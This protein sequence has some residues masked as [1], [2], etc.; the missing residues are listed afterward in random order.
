MKTLEQLFKIFI[1]SAESNGMDVQLHDKVEQYFDNVDT[2]AAF[3]LFTGAY[4][5]GIKD[6]DKQHW[7]EKK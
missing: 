4:W 2:Q 1:I 5:L 7:G 6:A 3:V